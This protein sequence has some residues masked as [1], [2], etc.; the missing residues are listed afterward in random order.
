M[1]MDERIG[2]FGNC[3]DELGIERKGGKC[4]AEKGLN[5][6]DRNDDAVQAKVIE[7]DNVVSAK[8][9][10]GLYGSRP[11]VGPTNQWAALSKEMGNKDETYFDSS[12]IF[13][14]LIPEITNFRV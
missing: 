7:S 11:A 2:K 13:T 9:G 4:E 1:G 8:N 5:S 14:S 10:L 6:G 12:K 3:S